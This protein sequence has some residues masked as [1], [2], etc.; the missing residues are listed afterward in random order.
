M[1]LRGEVPL[2]TTPSITE[3]TD[4]N[5]GSQLHVGWEAHFAYVL[6]EQWAFTGTFGTRW[7]YLGWEADEGFDPLIQTRA[8]RL[9]FGARRSFLRPPTFV[10][11]H[12]GAGFVGS[13]WRLEIGG[14]NG[15]RRASGPGALAGIE[16]QHFV[17]PRFAFTLELRGFTELHDA[18]RIRIPATDESRG[19]DFKH[20]SG[21]H[22]VSVLAG[23]L[24]R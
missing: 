9:Y 23:L 7:Q 18:E 3:A 10:S 21:Q 5:G 14:L 4:G 22:G 24:F 15:D 2:L 6:T 12:A 13:Y 1:G 8:M 11:V 20:S 17:N 19:W 16:L